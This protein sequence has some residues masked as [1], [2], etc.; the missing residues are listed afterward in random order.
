[1]T[2]KT[3]AM[4]I[5]AIRQRASDE[6]Y[7]RYAESKRRI[8]HNLPPKEYEAAMKRLAKRYHI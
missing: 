6:R 5:T 1:M 2:L 4:S 8:P 7:R 3:M